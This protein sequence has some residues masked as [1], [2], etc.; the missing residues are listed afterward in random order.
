VGALFASWLWARWVSALRGWSRSHV[1][2]QVE[3]A[4]RRATARDL[5]QL[6]ALGA[7]GH[8]VPEFELPGYGGVAV[9]CASL[10]PVDRGRSRPKP[11][12]RVPGA[13][14]IR[15]VPLLSRRLRR[16]MPHRSRADEWLAG[17]GH[18]R[19]HAC[20]E[21]VAVAREPVIGVFR[22]RGD[23]RRW[24]VPRLR[25][26]RRAHPA[27]HRRDRRGSIRRAAAP[28]ARRADPR[29]FSRPAR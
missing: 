6:R 28:I 15:S 23:A 14:S 26:L 8:A 19:A 10:Q 27:G 20:A 21:R 3:R 7:R 9:R 12:L 13:W 2:A 5:R 11:W 18:G 17:V 16:G 4:G 29:R 25:E 1:S 22:R 24:V